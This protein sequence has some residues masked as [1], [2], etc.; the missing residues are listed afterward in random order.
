VVGSPTAP[1][2]IH[3]RRGPVRPPAA[4]C[5]LPAASD[6]ASLFLAA[7]R[8]SAEKRMCLLS[9][10]GSFITLARSGSPRQ[11]VAKP[12]AS[13]CFWR[14]VVWAL[15]LRATPCH[16][17]PTILTSLFTSPP[18]AN[19][20]GGGRTEGLEPRHPM[21]HER[22]VVPPPPA[23]PP[24]GSPCPRPPCSRRF[25]ICALLEGREST[26]NGSDSVTTG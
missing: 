11:E 15:L 8:F 13:R 20:R 1:A 9:Y 6:S 3:L 17:L 18:K 2:A 24:G 25:R 22:R 4:S 23:P 12:S 14:L 10:S 26:L 19:L 16:M 7:P 21:S 5:G